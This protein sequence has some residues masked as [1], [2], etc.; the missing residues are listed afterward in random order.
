MDVYDTT[1]EN[2]R[3]A[4]VILNNATVTIRDNVVKNNDRD[5]IY[6][7]GSI[8]D[9][10][11]SEFEN[12]GL[13][14]A[15]TI[16]GIYAYGGSDVYLGSR[17]Y[18]PIPYEDQ[19]AGFNT[20]RNNRGAG[21]FVKNQ[22]GTKVTAGYFS[23]PIYSAGQNSLY[24][25][26]TKPGTGYTGKDFYNE[27]STTMNAQNNY[28]GGNCPPNTSQIYGNVT[29]SYCLG[30]PPSGAMAMPYDLSALEHTG[31]INTV[32]TAG[33]NSYD[34]TQF[35]KDLIV[36]YKR[37]IT[38]QPDSPQAVAAVQNYYS[39]VR[40]D[41]ENKLQERN[42]V[43]GYLN[44]KYTSNKNLELGNPPLQLMILEARRIEDLAT[45][46]SLSNTAISQLSGADKAGVM[47]NLAFSYIQVDE[48]KKAED[49]AAAFKTEFPKQEAEIEILEATIANAPQN[50]SLELA[51]NSKGASPI[52]SENNTKAISSSPD[53]FQLFHNY[54]NPFNPTT[55]IR[56]Q[57]P[58]EALVTLGIYNLLGQR[59][60]TLYEG[61][62]NAGFRQ[63]Q[64]DGKND[65]GQQVSS[66][67]YIIRLQAGSFVDSFKTTLVR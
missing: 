22:T 7:S 40:T 32:T 42:I 15:S 54:P 17:S 9:I 47:F 21:I 56:Y 45:A 16:H 49:I 66:G 65:F 29:T 13:G 62:Q 35:K 41:R 5:G 59:V 64:W 37:V 8:I 19:V 36:E 2:N 24:G 55:S 48:L 33:Q 18:I 27:R 4:F 52:I 25:N 11:D 53:G 14:D 12:N 34:D 51:A 50:I 30:S 26:G 6:T 57:L 10:F 61:R 3:H 38:E 31:R 46:I 20:I 44:G 28:W 23:F 58:E 43:S 60:R 39:L 67:V 1:L 63:V